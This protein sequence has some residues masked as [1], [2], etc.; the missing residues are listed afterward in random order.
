MTLLHRPDAVYFVVSFCAWAATEGVVAG[1]GAIQLVES[2]FTS[3]VCSCSRRRC[4]RRHQTCFPAAAL[5]ILLWPKITSVHA[6]ARFS[7]DHAVSSACTVAGIRWLCVDS[8]PQPPPPVSIDCRSSLYVLPNAAS[9]ASLACMIPFPQ[10][11]W[12]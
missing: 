9:Q 1:L 12:P 11:I 8:T 2:H 6:Q 5:V 4:G 3:K 10:D 7:L